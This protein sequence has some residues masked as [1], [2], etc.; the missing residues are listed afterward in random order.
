MIAEGLN[1]PTAKWFSVLKTDR[2]V[3]LP[4]RNQSRVCEGWGR[5]GS[6]VREEPYS[7]LCGAVEQ[8]DRVGCLSLA[9]YDKAVRERGFAFDAAN[10]GRMWHRHPRG[11]GEGHYGGP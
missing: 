3:S 7:A 9:G 2:D 10:I 4:R 1:D 8:R 5:S 6:S 11:E